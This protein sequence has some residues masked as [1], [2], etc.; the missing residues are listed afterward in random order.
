LLPIA[1][2]KLAAKSNALSNFLFALVHG[3]DPVDNIIAVKW[4]KEN[5][6]LPLPS[7]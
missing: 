4:Y 3:P 2:K 5:S 7:V 6:A 1:R